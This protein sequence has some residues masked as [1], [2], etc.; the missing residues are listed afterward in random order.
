MT[1]TVAAPI[2]DALPNYEVGGELGRGAMG[3]VFSAHHRRL[4]RDV[5]IKQ[6]PPA[7]AADQTVR[8]RFGKE[9][10]LNYQYQYSKQVS[11]AAGLAYFMPNASFGSLLGYVNPTDPSQGGDDPVT[12]FVV[13]ARVKF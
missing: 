7:F 8:E 2:R 13:E 10:D 4:A 12:R 3:V 5:A 6:L 9:A 11:L 1:V